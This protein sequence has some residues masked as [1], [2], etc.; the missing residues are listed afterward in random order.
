MSKSKSGSLSEW[1]CGFDE[2]RAQ[3]IVDW[4][5]RMTAKERLEAVEAVLLSI[6]RAGS[7]YNKRKEFFAATTN[8]RVE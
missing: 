5:T 4:A 3:Q 8:K 7:S 1:P 6:E 2:H